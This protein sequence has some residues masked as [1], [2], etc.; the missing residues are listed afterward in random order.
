MASIDEPDRY[1]F[2]RQSDVAPSE[3]NRAWFDV[4]KGKALFQHKIGQA[5]E[6]AKAVRA[7][8]EHKTVGGMTPGIT[9][10]GKPVDARN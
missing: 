6:V 4:L 1:V 10:K 5:L 7:R 3:V 9:R 8:W 2:R